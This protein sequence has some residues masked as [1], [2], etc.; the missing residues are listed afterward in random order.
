[1]RL[2]CERCDITVITIPR[3]ISIPSPSGAP[4]NKLASTWPPHRTY[5][6][7]GPRGILRDSKR[8]KLDLCDRE[9]DMACHCC[10][11]ATSHHVGDNGCGQKPQHAVLTAARCAEAA[12]WAST[13]SIAV[14]ALLRGISASSWLALQPPLPPNRECNR[15]SL[16]GERVERHEPIKR[17]LITRTYG[18]ALCGRYLPPEAAA[19]PRCRCRRGR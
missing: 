13:A 14:E 5:P 2:H 1:V 10:N 11:M 16:R 9:E 19:R 12:G 6:D 7:L 8:H 3:A 18:F 17:V 4:I 15:L